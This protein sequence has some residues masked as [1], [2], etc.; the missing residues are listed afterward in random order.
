MKSAY[1]LF[2]DA[3]RKKTLRG[4][5]YVYIMVDL[6]G[7]VLESTYNK[8]NDLEFISPFVKECLQYLSLQEDVKL[9]LW[10]S[11]HQSEIENV[12]KWLDECGIIFDYVNENPDEKNTEY[13]DFSAKPYFSIVL[14]DKAGWEA[15][16]W[17]CV[18]NW[19]NNVRGL[20]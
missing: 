9:I 6:H 5:K 10:T 8:K 20:D 14:D 15:S 4:W 13:A 11:S 19:I 18:H 1:N 17:E 12:R 3:W 7:V 2:K 16:D